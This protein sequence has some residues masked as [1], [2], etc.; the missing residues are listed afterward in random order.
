MAFDVIQNQKNI[1]EQLVF[2]LRSQEPVADFF[3][4]VLG[5]T[6]TY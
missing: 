1:L 3:F 6:S 2:V 4:N 5:L